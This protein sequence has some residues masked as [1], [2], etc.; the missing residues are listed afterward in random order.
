MNILYLDDL[1]NIFQLCNLNDLLLLQQVSNYYN[2]IINTNDYLWKF[3]SNNQWDKNFFN[4]AQRRNKRI[5]N[6]LQSYKK[7][8]LRIIKYTNHKWK[9]NDFYNHWYLS[10]LT[11]CNNS[12]GRFP[13]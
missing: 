8:I 11:L 7:E 10:E 4:I 13:I 2:N 3:A 1:I 5:S 9:I 6:P 12:K